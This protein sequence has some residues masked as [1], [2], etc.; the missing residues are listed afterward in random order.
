MQSNCVHMLYVSSV[1]LAVYLP[2]LKLTVE[3]MTLP[4]S[5]SQQHGIF[6]QLE[7]WKLDS[8]AK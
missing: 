6:P 3:Y 4:P 7:Q 1:Y 8:S 5:A 2:T